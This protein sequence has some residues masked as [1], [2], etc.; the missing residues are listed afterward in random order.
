MNEASNTILDFGMGS[1]VVDTGTYSDKP[2]VFIK[3]AI[4]AGPVGERTHEREREPL[5]DLVPGEVVLTFLTKE[6]AEE[7]ANLLCRPTFL[8]IPELLRRS[9]P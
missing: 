7:V 1:L 8:D 9:C 4:Q 6:M 2:A 5:D 3:R